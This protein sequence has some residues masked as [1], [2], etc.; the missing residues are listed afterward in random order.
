[1][2]FLRLVEDSDF[3]DPGYNRL[4]EGLLNGLFGPLGIRFLLVVVVENIAGIVLANVGTLTQ[5][6]CG[7]MGFPEPF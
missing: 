3:T 1:M 6:I 5:W 2:I 7:V 4:C